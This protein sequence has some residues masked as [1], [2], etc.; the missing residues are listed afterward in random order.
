MN[1]KPDVIVIG[2]GIAGLA[3]ASRLGQGGLSVL[4]LEARE[5]IGGR[6]W[7]QMDSSAGHAIEFGAEF[8]HGFPPEIWQPLQEAGAKPEEVE[9]D[10]WCVDDRLCPCNFFDQVDEI[11]QKMNDRKPDESFLEFLTRTVP[12]SNDPKKE[13][14]RRHA[15]GYV[16]GFNAADPALVGVHWLVKG[17]RAEELI[18]GQRAFRSGQGYEVLLA[19]FRKRVFESGVQV[20]SQM[21]VERIDWSAGS[22]SVTANSKEGAFNATAPCVVVTLPLA[23]L[24]APAGSLGA[25]QFVPALPPEKYAVLE[26]LEMGKVIRVVFQ[27]R[28]GFWATIS[29]MERKTLGRMSFLFSQ[30]DW[31]PTWWTAMPSEAPII[32][33]WAP[34]KSAERLTGQSRSFVIERGLRSLSGL[35]G[36][37]IE[38]IEGLLVEAF[39]HDWQTDPFSRG[40]YSYGKVNA[41][42]A[43][44]TL[45]RPVQNTLF[46]AGEA[47]DTTGQNGTVHAAIATG[48]RAA[49]EILR[50]RK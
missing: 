33:G 40:A 15:L 19:I 20:C 14:I 48:Y 49:E 13:S 50:G 45:A 46:F 7:T 28:Q 6:I 12:P 44:E 31:F 41:D 30:D 39:F 22:A 18:D 21:V 35:L 29:P 32:T 3:A 11:L 1:L 8:I 36:A 17:M 38:E 2:A 24:K 34:F 16:S 4:L 43:Q 37:S 25:V 23:V 27:F 9:G 26:R 47:T 42:G 10:S 5:R